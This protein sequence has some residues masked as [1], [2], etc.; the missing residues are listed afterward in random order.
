MI[1][2]SSL[3]HFHFKLADWISRSA[4]RLS[5]SALAPTGTLSFGASG[6]LG[7]AFLDL[8]WLR[9]G[10]LDFPA[11]VAPQP[12]IFWH[13][14][15]AHSRRRW[16]L[17]RAILELTWLRIGCL[18]FPARLAPQPG[19]FGALLGLFRGASGVLARAILDLTWLRVGCLDF[20]ARVAP[21]PGN[22]WR[23]SGFLSRRLWVLAR[24]LLVRPWPRLAAWIS[25]LALRLSRSLP[26]NASEHI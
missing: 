1:I 19:N 20:P 8:T 13:P 6:V 5:R 21:Q 24:A 25:R 22:F 7:Q 15:G 10:C 14:S 2:F 9:I 12:G 3:A 4:S 18:D 16:V 17:A 23:P 26:K 11:R